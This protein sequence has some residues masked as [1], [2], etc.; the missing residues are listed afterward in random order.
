MPATN[1][2]T[3]KANSSVADLLPTIG[4]IL[5]FLVFIP[6]SYYH[7]YLRHWSIDAQLFEFTIESI[8]L[9]I[10]VSLFNSTLHFKMVLGIIILVLLPILFLIV[11][12]KV[13]VRYFPKFG[14]SPKKSDWQYLLWFFGVLGLVVYFW[15]V[16]WLGGRAALAYDQSD[17]YQS[18][19]TFSDGSTIDEAKVI[20]TNSN[21]IAFRK[22]GDSRVYVYPF[23]EVKKITKDYS[24]TE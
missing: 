14:N 3:T 4:L 18:E 19:L 17:K 21:A 24:K 13:A 6:A 1:D 5:T 9:A 15:T 2:A 11:V 16:Y 12:D 23:N 20:A 10:G 22:K 7:G 8:G